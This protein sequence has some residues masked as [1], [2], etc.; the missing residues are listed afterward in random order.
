MPTTKTRIA[1]CKPTLILSLIL[2]VFHCAYLKL[3]PLAVCMH[4]FV[5]LPLAQSSVLCLYCWAILQIALLSYACAPHWPYT[6]HWLPFMC[7]HGVR[8]AATRMHTASWAPASDSAFYI[9]S[10]SCCWPQPTALCV[11]LQPAPATIEKSSA[12][13]CSLLCAPIPALQLPA[14]L[15]SN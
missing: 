3:A 15:S 1:H 2:G 13:P 8:C 4:T 7:E 11:H 10:N 14:L 6:H 12:D 9:D 5:V